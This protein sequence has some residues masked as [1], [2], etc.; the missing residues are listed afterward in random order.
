MILCRIFSTCRYHPIEGTVAFVAG[1]AYQFFILTQSSMAGCPMHTNLVWS[2][3]LEAFVLLHSGLVAWLQGQGL[4]SMFT[5][6][7]AICTAVNQIWYTSIPLLVK[8]SICMV[9]IGV[10]VLDAIVHF[11]TEPFRI[12][13][14][15][16][17]PLLNVFL[18]VYFALSFQVGK[19]ILGR[20]T[21]IPEYL[22]VVLAI[23]LCAIVA[24]LPMVALIVL[25]P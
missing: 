10:V 19:Y 9:V 8:A 24:F 2:G 16:R 3:N 5:F 23:A 13:T 20:C 22:V 25:I 21:K 14:S 4:I 1:F 7:F 11:S 18:V 12:F 6:G 15:L 17:I